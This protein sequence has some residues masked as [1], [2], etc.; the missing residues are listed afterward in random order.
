MLPD[1]GEITGLLPGATT[2][3]GKQCARLCREHWHRT[4]VASEIARIP[5]HAEINF[6]VVKAIADLKDAG[7]R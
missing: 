4:K 2:S 5:P 7:R 6:E 3:L 1:P